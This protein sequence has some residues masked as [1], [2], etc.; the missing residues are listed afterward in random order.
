MGRL[1]RI[2]KHLSQSDFS[3]I[4]IGSSISDVEAVDPITI[5]SVPSDG[6]VKYSLSFDTFHY[7]DDGILRITFAR[8]TVDDEYRVSEIEL[9]SSF[10]VDRDDGY[11]HLEGQEPLVKLKI[12]P[13]HL[14]S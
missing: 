9:N 8:E 10:E 13:E 11:S 5:L 2:S 12:N 4:T 6:A 1:L 3:N 7:T 14:P